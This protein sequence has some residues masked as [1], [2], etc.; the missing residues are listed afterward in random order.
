MSSSRSPGTSPGRVF[1]VEHLPPVAKGKWLPQSSGSWGPA[2]VLTFP[3][4]SFQL[5]NRLNGNKQSPSPPRSHLVG[6]L[7]RKCSPLN[8]GALG[9]HYHLIKARCCGKPTRK[10]R[11]RMTKNE[12][13]LKHSPGQPKG[14]SCS[15]S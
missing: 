1:L 11:L 14:T 5:H 7:A 15:H 4:F 13:L 9:K 3:T 8:R 10:G 2:I 6:R 12:A